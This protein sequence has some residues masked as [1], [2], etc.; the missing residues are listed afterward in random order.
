MI[1]TCH[2]LSSC[3]MKPET[4]LGM[5][6]IQAL[7]HYGTNTMLFQLSHQASWELVTLPVLKITVDDEDLFLQFHM[8]FKYVISH[9]FR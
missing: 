3:E 9:V 7:D 6:R 2:N 1:I 8:Q 4:N 5:N